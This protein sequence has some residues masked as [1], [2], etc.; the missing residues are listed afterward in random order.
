M[1]ESREAVGG[2]E[3]HREER[4]QNR[5]V[6][7]AQRTE[8]AQRLTNV[9]VEIGRL[10][11]DLAV[12]EEKLANAAS[13]NRRATEERAV[14][15]ARSVQSTRDAEAATEELG[16]AQT[17]FDGIQQE[18]DGRAQAEAQVRERL[19]K[20]RDH[21]RQLE[22]DGQNRTHRVK[23]YEG[24]RGALEVDLQ[25]LREQ[26]Q[27]AT[28][29]AAKCRALLTA[30]QDKL[31][32]TTDRESGASDA[33][34]KASGEAERCRHQV[35]ETRELEASSRAALRRA[36]ETVAQLSARTQALKDLERDRVGLAPG[37]AKLLG[38][39]AMFG[40]A[41]LGPLSDFISTGRDEAAL[42]ERLL[43]EWV[44]AVLVRD[45]TA[46]PAIQAWHAEA[47]A[48][49]L[50]LLP[51]MPPSGHGSSH[52]LKD[53][54]TVTS[55]V[56]EAWVAALL[57]GSEVIDDAGRILKQGNGAVLI[58]GEGGP[59]G[60]LQRRAELETLEE[61]VRGAEL[62][63]DEARATLTAATERLAR[64]EREL[65]EAAAAAETAREEERTALAAKDDAERTTAS[66]HRELQTMDGQV[67]R[68]TQRVTGTEQRIEE[69]DQALTHEALAQART[70]EELGTAREELGTLETEQESA[71]EARV[72]WQVQAAHIEGRLNSAKDK[73]E[74]ARI[75][76]TDAEATTE[77]LTAEMARLD[78][79][80]AEISAKQTVWKERRA[81]CRVASLELEAA[82][83]DAEEALAAANDQL[84]TAERSLT[85]ARARLEELNEEHHHLE[86]KLAEVAADRRGIVERVETE[87]KKP[88]ATLMAEVEPLELEL[89][90]LRDESERI[91][92]TLEKIGPVNPLAVEEH[93]EETKRLEFLISQRDD[94]VAAR[95][96]LVQAIREIDAT[97]KA[98]FLETFESVRGHFLDVFQ[99]LFGGGECD[100]RLTDPEDP[101]ESE[102][103]IHAAPR[104]KRTQRIHLLSSGERTLVAVSLLFSIYLTKPSPFC[105]MDEV[106]APLDDA[107]VGRFTRLLDQFKED[108]Q[109]IVITHNPRTM[110]SAD[111]IYGVTMQEPGCSTI[112]GVRLT[113]H[114]QKEGIAHGTQNAEPRAQGPDDRETDGRGVSSGESRSEVE[115]EGPESIE[116]TLAEPPPTPKP[117]RPEATVG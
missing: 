18:L 34:R 108:T 37:A 48:G 40:D 112:V 55:S 43:G 67:D 60:P 117:P 101:L 17:E 1:P 83:R 3:R 33:A 66:L 51:G 54:V 11:G 20:S 24:E 110:H 8:I 93:A 71:R 62:A 52:P 86:L 69:L 27:H 59:S 6:V 64:V 65:T 42:A 94:L 46:I 97:A 63:F 79:D 95:Q 28:S 87:W 82:S 19:I 14:M 56:A 105:L 104:G 7:E 29:D 77:R 47:D 75:T 116:E 92:D 10:D 31:R 113:D 35:A 115:S 90:G 99:T 106:D 41:V 109:F 89:E 15:Q 57:G 22:E 73:L 70:D 13:R 44:H 96:S 23:S 76:R 39:R 84:D 102:I 78:T 61:E 12:A 32:S 72:H 2:A 5:T 45:E 68:L 4:A 91:R 30:A 50:V 100:L 107:N 103:E 21:V 74:R 16:V 38:H 85:T 53:R 88:L 81:E 80:S 36:E 9:Q 58:T 49:A 111:A 25:S 114:R 98:M 26:V